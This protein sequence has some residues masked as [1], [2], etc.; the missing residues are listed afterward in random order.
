MACGKKEDTDSASSK[1]HQI[2]GEDGMSVFNIDLLDLS[3]EDTEKVFAFP[4][5][6]ISI[7]EKLSYVIARRNQRE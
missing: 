7:D 4:E 3:T 1:K 5:M 2:D 6:R